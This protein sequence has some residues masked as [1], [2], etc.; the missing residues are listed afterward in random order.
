MHTHGFL[1]SYF[2]IGRTIAEPGRNTG[3][4]IRAPRDPFDSAH[5]FQALF[6]NLAMGKTQ[7]C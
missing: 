3:S 6:P 7:M 5:A 1:S 2:F 4:E